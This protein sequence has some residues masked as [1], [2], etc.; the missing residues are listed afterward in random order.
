MTAYPCGSQDGWD[1]V[2]KDFA[3]ERDRMI[4]F[5]AIGSQLIV[6]TSL[7]LM[8][9]LI[10][11]LQVKA[12]LSSRAAGFLLSME[13]VCIGIYDITS[14]CVFSR[15]FHTALGVARWLFGHFGYGPHLPLSF[16]SDTFRCPLDSRDRSRDCGCRGDKYFVAWN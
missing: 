13:L 7:F 2:E 9:I 12:G 14:I 16:S 5:P 4:L 1:H 8:P 3:V 15:S 10:D 11:S 6:S